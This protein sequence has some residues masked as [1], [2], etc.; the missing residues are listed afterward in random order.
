MFMSTAT[1]KDVVDGL[2]QHPDF[3]WVP[4]LDKEGKGVLED[5]VHA[6]VFWA[7]TIADTDPISKILSDLNKSPALKDMKALHGSTFFITASLDDKIADL[8]DKMTKLGTVVGIVVDDKG[9]PTYC[10]TKQN[11]TSTQN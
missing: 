4:V 6:R 1:K 2:S 9:K 10:F 8:S 5:I 7:A 11:I 3:W